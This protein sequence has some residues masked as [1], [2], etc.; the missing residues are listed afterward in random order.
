DAVSPDIAVEAA[1]DRAS[2]QEVE[3]E[4]DEGWTEIEEEIEEEVPADDA[5]GDAFIAGFEGAAGEEIDDDIREV[6][7][8]EVAEEIDNLGRQVPVWRQAPDNL[9]ELKS[10]RRSFHTLKGS[11]RL[12]GAL[13]LGEFS[14]KV[15]NMLNRVLDRTIPASPAVVALIDRALDALPRLHAALSG[16]AAKGGDI[17]AIMGTADRIAAGEQVFVPESPKGGT[18]KV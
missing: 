7:L 5:D 3:P 2:V 4:H 1:T 8:E 17:P 14:W 6:F 13:T 9:D 16:E 18:R 15:E 12:V 11:G 10:I